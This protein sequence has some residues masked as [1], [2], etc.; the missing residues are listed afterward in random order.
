[1]VGVGD[2]VV[3]VVKSSKMHFNRNSIIESLKYE[4]FIL[5]VAE[6]L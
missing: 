4:S 1:M 5:N 6:E 3:Y 2:W